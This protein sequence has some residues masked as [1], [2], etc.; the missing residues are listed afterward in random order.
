MAPQK[1]GLAAV[2]GEK[3][4]L[5]LRHEIRIGKKTVP[6]TNLV[7]LRD[8]L[9]SSKIVNFLAFIGLDYSFY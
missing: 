8:Y 5:L 4:N 7:V 1:A 9:K 6:R 2:S 3:R